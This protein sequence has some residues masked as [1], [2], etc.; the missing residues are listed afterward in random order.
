M[1]VGLSLSPQAMP[2][3]IFSAS[4]KANKSAPKAPYSPERA[5]LASVNRVTS[6]QPAATM[7][8]RVATQVTGQ[9]MS[10]EPWNEKYVA[11]PKPMQM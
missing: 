8:T 1:L 7:A 2:A 11:M 10:P 9:R 5:E 6:A 3:G 4:I